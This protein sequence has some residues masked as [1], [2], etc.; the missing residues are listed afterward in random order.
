MTA[1][2]LKLAGKEFV[3]LSK[4]DYVALKDRAA[5]RT[6]MA[7]SPVHRM[8]QQDRGDVAEA[9]RILADPKEKFIP[10]NEVRKRIG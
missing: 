1:T 5:K 7:D 2:V 9:K 4:R 8:T 10:W 3:I 6:S